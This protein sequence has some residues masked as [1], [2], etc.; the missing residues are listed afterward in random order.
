[1][2]LRAEGLQI[3]LCISRQEARC[4]A[5]LIFL[6]QKPGKNAPEPESRRC[7]PQIKFLEQTLSRRGLFERDE[8][9]A[10]EALH[11]AAAD[12]AE[13]VR[14]GSLGFEMAKQPGV[15]PFGS[16][17]HS[18]QI[19]INALQLPG[20]PNP[21]NKLPSVFRRA[22]PIL[23]LASTVW[24]SRCAFTIPQRSSEGARIFHHA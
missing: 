10:P 20:V 6:W 12:G 9:V 11:P 1:M 21:C 13:P 18:R 14:I 4:F 3:F 22:L 2:A 15:D 23:A 17:F 24:V 7:A 5:F 16:H 19:V 8:D